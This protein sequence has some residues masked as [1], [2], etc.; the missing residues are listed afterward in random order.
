MQKLSVGSTSIESLQDWQNMMVARRIA[1]GGGAYHEHVTR[2]FP[3]QKEAL[4]DGG[5]IYWVIKGMIIC[6]N[7]II[8]LEPTR[9]AK[10]LKACSIQMDPRLIA[11]EPAPR[12]AFQGWRYLK[13]EDV[14]ADIKDIDNADG[15]SPQLRQKLVEI[16]AW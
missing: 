11:V 7:S 3:K 5:S 8:A 15:I 9:N 14:P 6:R 16:G 10:G 4:L 12:R 1:A 2:M 13:A